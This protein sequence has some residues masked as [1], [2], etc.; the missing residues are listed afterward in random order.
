MSASRWSLFSEKKRG[1][2]Q[3]A[4]DNTTKVVI[5]IVVILA[6]IGVIFLL[7]EGGFKRHYKT[8]AEEMPYGWEGECCTCSRALM[9]RYGAVIPET[10]ELIFQDEHVPDCTAACAEAHEYT[11]NEQARYEVSAFISNDPVCRTELPAPRTY[12]GAGGFQ[13]QPVQDKY[14]IT[15]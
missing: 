7:R 13:N 3:M 11:R 4:Q 12:A 1:E 5:S 2:Y 15:S 8:A 9:N 14:F 6:L 10:R